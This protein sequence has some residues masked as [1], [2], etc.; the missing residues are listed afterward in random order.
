[1]QISDI[2][3]V[4]D[5]NTFQRPIYAGNALSTVRSDEAI[6]IFTVRRTAFEAVANDGGAASIEDISNAQVSDECGGEE[7]QN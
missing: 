3:E 4:D 7:K 2:I 6:K 5:A 1:M